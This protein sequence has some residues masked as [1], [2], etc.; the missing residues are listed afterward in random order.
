[1]T[2]KNSLFPS[3][4]LIRGSIGIFLLLTCV[5]VLSAETLQQWLT[6]SG[7][8]GS[9]CLPEDLNRSLSS[10]SEFET[11]RERLMATYVIEPSGLL[12][13]YFYLFRFDKQN[14]QWQSSRLKWPAWEYGGNSPHQCTGG[15]IL[16]ILAS[17]HFFY[18]NG[19]INPSACCTMVI[20][21]D[22]KFHDT[23]YGW[24]AALGPADQVV[25]ENS[26]V[27]F[28]PTHYV[29]FSIYHP[30]KK[31]LSTL[32]PSKS[33]QPVREHYIEAVKRAYAPCCTRPPLPGCT[34]P[35]RFGNHHCNPELFDN[36]LKGEVEVNPA[37]ETLAFINVF[38]DIAGTEEIVYFY[39]HF[40]NGVQREY[41]EM[42][43]AD[44][45]KDFGKYPLKKYLTAPV[46]SRIFAR[47]QGPALH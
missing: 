26:Q 8:P 25:V 31:S 6:T 14:R 10:G 29:E 18:L 45:Y 39:R 22:L 46:L 20:S 47:E 27:Y 21:K 5:K 40:N 16:Q 33:F 32:H 34:D 38:D 36:Y 9:V 15:S 1:M 13:D 37:T 28:A 7:A 43:L 11:D 30:Q 42:K 44:L 2:R 41:R 12:P 24:P 35:A 23:F 4:V 17:P 19:H 3:S